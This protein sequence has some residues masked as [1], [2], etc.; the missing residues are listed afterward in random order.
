MYGT[1]CARAFAVSDTPSL[2]VAIAVVH[3]VSERGYSGRV[4]SM[5]PK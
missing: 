3:A 2:L 1:Q 4:K 5:V